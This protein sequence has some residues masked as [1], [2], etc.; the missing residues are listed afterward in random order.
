[1]IAASDVTPDRHIE[2]LIRED[3]TRNIR[4]HEPRDDP[5]I[6]SVAADEARKTNNIIGSKRAQDS[7]RRAKR[8]RNDRGRFVQKF[9]MI[10]GLITLILTKALKR[11]SVR[12]V[13]L[14]IGC[15]SSATLQPAHNVSVKWN[16]FGLDDLFQAIC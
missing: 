12:L 4:L 3:Q 14:A 9:K 11:I 15:P 10:Q 8:W 2:W 5:R 13:A 7:L 16:I 1:M 6:S